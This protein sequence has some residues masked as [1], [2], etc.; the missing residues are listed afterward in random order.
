MQD[1]LCHKQPQVCKIGNAQEG[2]WFRLS[3]RHLE[4]NKKVSFA[5]QQK[6]STI[7]IMNPS[8]S[9]IVELFTWKSR[10]LIQYATVAGHF[11]GVAAASAKTK[12]KKVNKLEAA[13]EEH[14][15]VRKR[16]RPNAVTPKYKT[17]GEGRGSPPVSPP[18]NESKPSEA[19]KRGKSI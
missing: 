2:D 17:K 13:V 6:S 3:A 12:P 18:K 14:P 10:S 1:H 19:N 9:E 4:A 8:P 16:L 7:P 11:P 5:F 15:K